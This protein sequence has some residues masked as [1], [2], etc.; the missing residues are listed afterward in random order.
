[1]G[2]I[3]FQI[4]THLNFLLM[5]EEK[6]K[7]KFSTRMTNIKSINEIEVALAKTKIMK[8]YYKTLKN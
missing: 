8:T 7:I 3:Q 4:L 6:F 2:Q 5:I 1:M